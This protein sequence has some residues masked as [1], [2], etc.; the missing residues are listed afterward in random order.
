MKTN[1]CGLLTLL[2]PMLLN[3]DIEFLLRKVWWD[4]QFDGGESYGS[5]VSL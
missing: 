3:R 5:K 4:I 2:G 1:C